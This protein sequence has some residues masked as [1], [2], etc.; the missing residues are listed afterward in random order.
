[1]LIPKGF[2]MTHEEIGTGLPALV[3]VYDPNL[4]VNTSQTEQMNKA[5]EMLGDQVLFLIAKINTPEGDQ[6]I[7][8]HRANA[9]ELLLFNPSGKLIKR[10]FALRNS[11]ELIQWIMLSEP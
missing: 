4:A 6:L 11:S 5:R 8:K 9:A 10:Q 2:K 3:F 1:M 7:A